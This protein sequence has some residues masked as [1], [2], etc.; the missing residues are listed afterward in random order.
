MSSRKRVH[1]CD[2]RQM[3]KGSSTT[4]N[5][6][7]VTAN[8]AAPPKPSDTTAVLVEHDDVTPALI[9]DTRDRSSSE[10]KFD[11]T[12]VTSH[13]SNEN[14][15]D[16]I[17][18]I[19]TE[20]VCTRAEPKRDEA[21]LATASSSAS[22]V[23]RSEYLP[24]IVKTPFQPNVSEIIKMKCKSRTLTFQQSWFSK[25]QWLHYDPTLSG[26]LCHIC[27]S[28]H[29]TGKL[30]LAKNTASAFISEGFRHWGRAL[31]KF[32]GHEHSQCH[33]IAVQ[34]L[35]QSRTSQPINALISHQT[36]AD[37]EMARRCIIKV[38]SS[39]RYLA[40][41][42]LALTGND[43]GGNFDQLMMLRSEDMPELKTWLSRRFDMT[44]SAIQNELLAM[45][46]HA[47]IRKICDDI[48][49]AKQFSIIVDGTQ[50]VSGNEQESICIR[51]VDTKTLQPVEAFL[52][53]YAVQDT[54]GHAMAEMIVDV[55]LRLNLSIDN[56][57]GQTYDGAANMSGAYNG[58][59]ALIRHK[60]PLAVFVHCG[61]HC[62]NLV[63]QHASEA[64][65][66]VKSSMAWLQELGN[67]YG[68]SRKYRQSFRDI[69]TLHSEE[70]ASHS[71][72]IKPAIKPLCPTRWLTRTPAIDSVV[73]QYKAVLE[74]LEQ[75]SVEQRGTR[76]STL[77]D[78]AQN[79]KTLLGLHMSKSV[80]GLLEQLNK[81]L[82]SSTETVS[83][84]LQAVDVVRRQLLNIRT[85]EKFALLLEK[86][87][88]IAEELQLDNISLPRRR[89]VPVRF[90]GPAVSHQP[91]TVEEYYRKQYFELID[92]AIMQLTDRFDKTDLQKYQVLQE[93]L[94]TGSINTDIVQL[95]PELN[96]NTLTIQL[97]MFQNE[98]QYKTVNEAVKHMQSLVP[99]VRKLFTQV[100]QL[101]ILLL[102]NPASSATAER[103]FSSLRRLKTWL[104]ATMSQSRL[105]SL[106]VCN[107]HRE[108]LDDV[109]IRDVAEEFASR[110]DFRQRLFGNFA[111]LKFHK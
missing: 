28:A 35:E 37:Q 44:S 24:V 30:D 72:A 104:R 1:N 102:V 11:S 25:F 71:S 70:Q 13:L 64:S 60:Q 99:A 26:V 53:M 59:Q 87:S 43:D 34:Q 91:E 63:A 73:E 106:A 14:A 3:F 18:D 52:G 75:A 47:L 29:Q 109:N 61:A 12:S 95:Y 9:P 57:R 78:Q 107:A 42:G 45:F 68:S 85:D 10:L 105:N 51:Y 93:I 40:R 54:N 89:K 36:L 38:V 97:P 16:I 27:S 6:A 46:G 110:N 33:R 20:N 22:S 48:R 55:L 108:L 103:S 98:F 83:E 79:S 82:Q 21:D 67:F 101:L 84:M 32:A 31:E 86:V 92:V 88:K 77:V 39:I 100:E 41:Q 62:V 7:S 56:L 65:E 90:T 76:A 23:T 80:F 69:A 5:V 50:D 96:A 8:I 58:C 15:S 94:L 111:N 4:T 19:Q 66:S 49:S 2:I 81:T 74:S 17:P